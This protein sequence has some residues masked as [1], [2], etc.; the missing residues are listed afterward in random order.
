ML[1]IRQLLGL[2]PRNSIP[3]WRGFNL[4]EK[5]SQDALSTFWREDFELIAEWGF[6]GVR[7]PMT[8][9]AWVR[10]GNPM[11][12]DETGQALREIDQAVR[13]A[14]SLG[15]HVCIAFHRAPG[16]SVHP[17]RREPF[18]LWTDA[19]ALECCAVHWRHFARRYQGVP[20]GQ[21]S[22]NLWNEPPQPGT[23]GMTRENHDR[24]ARHVIGTI[25]AVDPA[26]PIVLDGLQWGNQPLPE[27][28]D[29]AH[30]QI[31]QS[32]RGYAPMELTHYRAAWIRGADA[33]PEPTWPIQTERGPWHAK[34][35][36]RFYRPW[37]RMIR[38]GV[39]V[40]CGE[41][42][43]YRHTPHTA[44]L[45]WMRDL[46]AELRRRR[47]GYGLWNFRGPFGV[48]DSEREDVEY[49]TLRRHRLDRQMLDLLQRDA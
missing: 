29:I 7:L 18:N 5:F 45:A 3:R 12:I 46:L 17:E 26:R 11:A 19:Q 22:F 44:A 33:W 39:G 21:L 25:R 37:G 14:R 9:M 47:I 13:W 27:L 30:Q 8:Y 43:V 41:I 49:E 38:Q 36:G 10:N 32:C 4:L 24:A 1:N 23:A 31:W 35:L 48:L 2:E 20:D 34:A 16:Y 15:L 40:H 6:N 42:G 28:A